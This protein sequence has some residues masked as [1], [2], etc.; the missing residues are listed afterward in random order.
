M[1]KPKKPGGRVIIRTRTNYVAS[2]GAR[3]QSPKSGQRESW[4]EK[5]STCTVCF[6]LWA[7][8]VHSLSLC[9]LTGACSCHLSDFFDL[10]KAEVVVCLAGRWAAMGTS[11]WCRWVSPTSHVWTQMLASKIFRAW[12]TGGDSSSLGWTWLKK[13]KLA[14]PSSFPGPFG[15]EM[16]FRN[17]PK[18]LENLQFCPISLLHTLE[19]R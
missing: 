14:A 18:R 17:G 4:W 11:F 15:Q 2:R 9:A 13:M 10:T 8:L 12:A 6:L 16:N 7:P 1:K 19:C 3:L 5:G